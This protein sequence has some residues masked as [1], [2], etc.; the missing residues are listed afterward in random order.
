MRYFYLPDEDV[1]VRLD[2]NTGSMWVFQNG[3]WVENYE[4]GVIFTGDEPYKEI[5]RDQVPMYTVR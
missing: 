2:E 1:V 5:T 4:Y 3:D